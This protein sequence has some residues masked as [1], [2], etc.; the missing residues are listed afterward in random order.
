MSTTRVF[1]ALISCLLF[2]PCLGFAAQC[3]DSVLVSQASVRLPIPGQ[4]NSAAFM[5][6]SNE[7]SQDCQLIAAESSI[8][9]LVELHTHSN[10]NGIMRMRAVESIDIPT[11][12]ITQ[13]KPGGLHLMLIDLLKPIAA[14]HSVKLTLKY[15]DGSFNSIYPP[16]T[17][18]RS[19]PNTQDEKQ[20]DDKHD[21]HSHDHHGHHH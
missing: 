14:G 21:G 9:K 5:S 15:A 6:L 16:V 3:A 13:L 1:R 2:A 17:D 8:A 19:L 11:G 10:D 7:S 12:E 20:A 4:N 18:I